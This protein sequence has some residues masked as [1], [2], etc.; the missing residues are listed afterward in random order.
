M[1]TVRA[2]AAAAVMASFAA[3]ALAQPAAEQQPTQVQFQ[4]HQ[5]V[6]AGADSDP[7]FLKIFEHMRRDCEL[8][9]KAFAR[10]CAI[11][12]INIYS[13]A[14]NAGEPG[15]A[16]TVNATATMVLPPEAGA[17]PPPAEK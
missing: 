16:V 7:V 11:R 3:A 15:G 2:L 10:K 1:R 13:N 4:Y 12:Q 14:V 17:P 5:L 9:G 8:I 6:P